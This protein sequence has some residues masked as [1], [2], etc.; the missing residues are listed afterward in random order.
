VPLEMPIVMTHKNEIEQELARQAQR[1]GTIRMNE[2]VEKIVDGVLLP[3]NVKPKII[4]GA[5]G[6]FSLVRDYI[7]VRRP[8]MGIAAEDLS[9]NIEMDPTTCH[10]VMNRAQVRCGYI[11]YFPKND[12]WNIGIGCQEKNHF[13][14]AFT[15]FKMQHDETKWRGGFFACG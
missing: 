14:T 8:N 4:V 1:Q 7:G 15:A 12:W 2:K 3:Q 11:W 9:A 5:D 10:V 13:Q 6:C